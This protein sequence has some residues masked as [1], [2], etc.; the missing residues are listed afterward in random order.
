M[1]HSQKKLTFC[2]LLLVTG[3]PGEAIRNRKV[4]QVLIPSKN[5]S[6]PAIQARVLP[7][8]R[9]SV[10]VDSWL[11][12]RTIMDEATPA[13]ASGAV[14]LLLPKRTIMEGIMDKATPALASGAV[15]SW[16]PK[17]IITAGVTAKPTPRST[18]GET[19]AATTVARGGAT[20]GKATGTDTFHPS[21]VTDMVA[22]LAYLGKR[23]F[24]L[25]TGKASINC[26]A[27]FCRGG[28][29][30][31]GLAVGAGFVGGAVA[32]IYSMQMYHRYKKYQS[33]MYCH[34]HG[35]YHCDFRNTQVIEDTIT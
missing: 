21:V 31:F 34:G 11:T 17:R 10:G 7:P 16:P 15:D 30:A 29:K 24:M 6:L 25:N 19:M 5:T 26:H 9:S 13:L 4:T 27:M 22:R 20:D 14:D 8:A 23:L 18:T 1:L 32:G 3:F 35:G 12:N 2:F 33:M 28:K